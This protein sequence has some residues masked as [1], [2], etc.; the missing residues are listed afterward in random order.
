MSTIKYTLLSEGTSD[1]ALLHILNWLLITYFPDHAIQSE[2][3]DLSWLPK[4]PK[5]L[6]DKID[7]SISLYPCNILFV[8]RDADNQGREERHGVGFRGESQRRVEKRIEEIYDALSRLETPLE[9]PLICVIPVRMT[10]AW[11]LFDEAAIR[12]AADNPNGSVALK[13]PNLKEIENCADPK[14]A[15]QEILQ[16]A[17]NCSGR[18]MKKFKSRISERVLRISELTKDFSPLRQLSAFRQLEEEVEKLRE[19]MDF[20]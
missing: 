16:V 6:I 17:G 19:T 15:L 1:K 12:M 18:R 13:F 20:K 4:P 2:W 3:A 8:H 14:S 10:E 9:I 7:T 11:L 5:E